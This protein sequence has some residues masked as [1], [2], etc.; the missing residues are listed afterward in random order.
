MLDLIFVLT[1]E[2]RYP[3]EVFICRPVEPLQLQLYTMSLTWR[4][5]MSG[6]NG[7]DKRLPPLLVAHSFRDN[8]YE[9]YVTDLKDF[10]C[11][12]MDRRDI[13]KRALLTDTSID[14]TED[15]EQMKLLLEKI[16]YGLDH[17]NDADVEL[18]MESNEEDGDD[19]DNHGHVLP[20]YIK[21]T[22]DLPKPFKPLQWT[23]E[24]RPCHSSWLLKYITVP[25]ILAN[26]EATNEAGSL[27]SVIREKDHVIQKLADKLEA[28]GTELGEVFPSAAGK[29]GRKLTRKM[30]EE[31][32]AG[33]AA[34]DYK[35]WFEDFKSG[36]RSNELHA[37][38]EYDEIVFRCFIE[39]LE[40]TGGDLDWDEDW[41]GWWKKLKGESL[42]VCENWGRKR[43]KNDTV[44]LEKKTPVKDKPTTNESSKGDL[45][46][47]GTPPAADQR[48]HTSPSHHLRNR[49]VVDDD[50]TD[51]EDLDAAS[52][53]QP[54]KIPDSFCS[55]QKQPTKAPAMK[56]GG[57]GGK[58]TAARE[59]SRTPPAGQPPRS[60]QSQ[61]VAGDDSTEGEDDFE[62][63]Q[64]KKTSPGKTSSQKR[65]ASITPPPALPSPKKSPK[66]GGLGKI[67]GKKK[68][69]SPPPE[70]SQHEE[71][72]TQGSQIP[73]RTRPKLGHVGRKEGDH[74]EDGARGRSDEKEEEKPRETSAE[75]RQRRKREME[76]RLEKEAAR[77]KKKKRIF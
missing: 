77:P 28:S 41:E 49:Y 34:F 75:A 33:L 59:K 6:Q 18:T 40:L 63:A 13:N 74:E 50:E 71:T 56:L 19:D 52:Q 35:S 8:G 66:K 44:D 30:V 69:A 42:P 39:G 5:L 47:P 55:P 70:P 67:G 37:G 21:M 65:A 26:Y 9:V 48:S 46:V 17:G 76:E 22:I 73:S 72:Q 16:K 29:G 57:I 11:E 4:Y 31:R 58:K 53:S 43:P 3:D 20:M 12:T 45:Q 25:L 1:S 36:E 62:E 61:T 27:L 2:I 7:Y 24:L 38:Q 60:S 54:N 15:D 14:P 23:M 51:D 68:A 32:V 10:W 64:P